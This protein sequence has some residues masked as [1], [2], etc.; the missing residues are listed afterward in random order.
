MIKYSDNI[1]TNVLIDILGMDNINKK[2]QKLGLK[3]T[4]LNRK[5]IKEGEQNYMSWEDI[6]VILKGI[7]YKKNR[8]YRYL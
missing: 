2:S 1:A 6:E 5:M 4:K 3:A 8:K 7:F